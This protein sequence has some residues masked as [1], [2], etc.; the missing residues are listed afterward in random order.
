MITSATRNLSVL[1]VLLVVCAGCD[2]TNIESAMEDEE[3]VSNGPGEVKVG[4]EAM[5]SFVRDLE[6]FETEES[7]ASII[8]NN[9]DGENLTPEELLTLLE[10]RDT[11][12]Y[13]H[14]EI[15]QKPQS[16]L[17]RIRGISSI[18]VGDQ[19]LRIER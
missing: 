7:N 3:T 9:T 4:D 8:I 14:R 2:S 12:E 17:G 1:L 19:P 6:R 5:Q 15:D 13:E 16:G 10:S 18:V 11:T